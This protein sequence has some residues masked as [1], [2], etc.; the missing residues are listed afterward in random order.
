MAAQRSKKSTLDQDNARDFVELL[1]AMV[2]MVMFPKST[3]MQTVDVT[4]LEGKSLMWMAK[5]NPCVMSEYARGIGVPLSSATHIIDRLVEKNLIIRRRSDTDR[6]IV[7]IELSEL[8]MRRH[9]R[10]YEQRLSSSN[11]MLATLS[12]ADRTNLIEILQ[13]MVSAATVQQQ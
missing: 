11:L 6:R 4:P 9:K 10:F 3:S 13:R 12:D 8:A 5:H 7:E 1:D 2:G